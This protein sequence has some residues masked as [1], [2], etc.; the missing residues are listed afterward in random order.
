MIFPAIIVSAVSCQQNAPASAEVKSVFKQGIESIPSSEEEEQNVYYTNDTIPG[1]TSKIIERIINGK[2]VRLNLNGT[3]QTNVGFEGYE[4]PL[5]IKEVY[6]GVVYFDKYF[7]GEQYN[8][9][10]Q[11]MYVIKKRVKGRIEFF[12][13]NYVLLKIF[14]IDKNNPYLNAPTGITV[15]EHYSDAE[16]TYYIPFPERKN[17]GAPTQYHLRYIVE[18]QG[19]FSKVIYWKDEVTAN[20][21]I[22]GNAST[23][24][25][26]DAQGEEVFRHEHPAFCSMPVVSPDGH[27]ALYALLPVETTNNAGIKTQTDGFDIW[28]TQ[29][30][31]LLHREMNSDPDMWIGTPHVRG[32]KNY[33]FIA[34][35]YPNSDKL[36][37]KSYA[38][39]FEEKILWWRIITQEDSRKVKYMKD[40]TTFSELK[41]LLKFNQKSIGNE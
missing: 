29:T 14:D 9:R 21:G 10:E 32:D 28:D 35:S 13:T 22:I 39:E 31:K 27:Y 38:F 17:Q 40:Y 30:K 36:I 26:L 25:V 34:Y 16:G 23:M 15:K 6:P 41:E 24:I 11:Q 20:G 19:P 33:L 18:N 8:E 2:T 12:D 1:G 7:E 5:E 3:F 37:S 4:Y